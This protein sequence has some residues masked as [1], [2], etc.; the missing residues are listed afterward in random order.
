[1]RD[2]PITHCTVPGMNT[3]PLL[4]LPDLGQRVALLREGETTAHMGPATALVLDNPQQS[5]SAEP[6]SDQRS[7]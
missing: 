2:R 5:R 4:S 6:F 7:G 1:M 3:T